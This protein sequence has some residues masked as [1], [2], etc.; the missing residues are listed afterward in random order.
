[1]STQTQPAAAPDAGEPTAIVADDKATALAALAWSEDAEDYP[2][3]EKKPAK[4]PEPER[5]HQPW[6][7]AWSAA[8]VILICAAVVT[9]A[10][11]AIGSFRHGDVAPVDTTPAPAPTL[12]ETPAA[13]PPSGPDDKIVPSAVAPAPT[14]PPVEAAPPTQTVTVTPTPTLAAA[15]PAQP[16]APPRPSQ[17]T[18]DEQFLNDLTGDGMAIADVQA[19]IYGGHATCAYLAAGHTAAE[20]EETGMRNNASMTRAEAITYVNTAIAVY[21][22]QYGG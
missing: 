16:V 5:L 18:L 14:L 2:A 22:P 17:A 20:A 7:D 15:P 13:A 11:L 1:M 4:K 9:V 12:S 19:A 21:C 8:V 10:I 3:A 6:G